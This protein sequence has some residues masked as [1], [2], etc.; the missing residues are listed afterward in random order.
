MPFLS[1]SRSLSLCI[2]TYL[3][4]QF[5]RKRPFLARVV[6][7]AAIRQGASA[8]HLLRVSYP[9]ISPRYTGLFRFQS[10][11]I[12]FSQFKTVYGVKHNQQLNFLSARN[13]Y[14]YYNIIDVIVLGYECIN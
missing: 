3:A 12:S 2:R 13:L 8:W 14:I 7:L 10:M 11:N 1:E 5:Q 4:H 9:L 6:N